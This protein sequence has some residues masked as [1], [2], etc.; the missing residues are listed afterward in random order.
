ML[1]RGCW[2]HGY[3]AVERASRWNGDVGRTGI[4]PVINIFERS[5][6]FG[7]ALRG[8]WLRRLNMMTRRAPNA[9]YAPYALKIFRFIYP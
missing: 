5:K 1:E 8:Y 3:L 2:W 6:P 7:G 9:P 4:L